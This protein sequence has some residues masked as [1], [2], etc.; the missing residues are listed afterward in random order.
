[1]L[2]CKYIK[3]SNYYKFKTRES[4]ENP[5]AEG[6]FSKWEKVTSADIVVGHLVY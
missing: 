1:M 3:N 4:S 5:K 6:F 2:N